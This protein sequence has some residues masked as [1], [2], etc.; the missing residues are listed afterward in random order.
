MK[1]KNID[2]VF[3]LDRSGS[4]SGMEKDTIGGYNSYLQKERKNNSNSLITTVLFDNNYELLYDREQI[5]NVKDLTEKEYFVRGSTALLDAIG[6][7]ITSIDEKTDGKVLFVITTDGLENAS[8]IYKKEQ[9]KEMILGHTNWEFIFIGA[10]ID[11]FGEA[12]S[13][14]ISKDNTCN[15]EKSSFGIRKM[16]KA[17]SKASEDFG[18]YGK[19]DSSWK[20][21]LEQYMNENKS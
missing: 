15:Y 10:D 20:E 17:I 16:F 14:G 11:S 7:T 6:K 21:D 8:R 1:K 4:M 3:L 5:S 9:I 12:S 19:L 13:I 18:Y 2:I